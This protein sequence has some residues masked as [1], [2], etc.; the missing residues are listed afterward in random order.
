MLM[1]ISSLN[2]QTQV[3]KIGSFP[4]PLMV[5]DSHKGVFIDLFTELANRSGIKY[6]IIVNPTLR[7]VQNFNENLLM[8]FF[9]ALDVS[10]PKPVAASSEIYVKNDFVFVKSGIAVPGTIKEL[11]GKTIGLTRGYPYARE[12]T[13]NKKLI[14]DYADDD[15]TN[16]KKLAT[17]RIN[18][19][20]VEEKS[21]LTAMKQSGE[22]NITYNPKQPISSQKVYFAFQ[23]TT[24]GKL[25]AEKFSKALEE[26]KKDGT[27]AAIMKK[28]E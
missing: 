6:E 25:L 8:G 16:M 28:A 2:A 14:I 9:P 23:N 27:F 26:I 17:G 21:G 7:T 24:E 10:I 1:G 4:I 13:E 11:E 19:F 22:L 20:I 18:Y 3:Y 12:L 15:V 5:E